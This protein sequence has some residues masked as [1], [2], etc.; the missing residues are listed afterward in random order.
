[1]LRRHGGR[2]FVK[3]II[4]RRLRLDLSIDCSLEIRSYAWNDPGYEVGIPAN[5][6][7]LGGVAGIRNYFR[8]VGSA[9]L[10]EVG[11][12]HG[13]NLLCERFLLGPC[14]DLMAGDFIQQ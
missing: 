2:L 1:M 4:A 8:K 6:H 9:E 12:A 13:Q 7:A 14:Q 3:P 10:L 5:M 11:V